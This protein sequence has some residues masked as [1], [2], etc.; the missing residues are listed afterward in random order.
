MLFTYGHVPDEED[1]PLL[2]L[3]GENELEAKVLLCLV[4]GREARPVE[5]TDGDEDDYEKKQRCVEVK[6]SELARNTPIKT[7]ADV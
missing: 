3:V 7:L 4:V 5:V 6:V 2:L 1:S